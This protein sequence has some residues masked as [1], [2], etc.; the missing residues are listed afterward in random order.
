MCKDTLLLGDYP[1]RLLSC[2]QLTTA[3]AAQHPCRYLSGI[4]C[5]ANR[6]N[7]MKKRTTIFVWSSLSAKSDLVT[8][9]V[10]K[11][12]ITET[13]ISIGFGAPGLRVS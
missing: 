5:F 13:D 11:I 6:Y 7:Y 2:A 3:V 10:L 9:R 12:A 8:L 4:L 1:L